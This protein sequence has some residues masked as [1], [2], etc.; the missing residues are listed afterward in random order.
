MKEE[1]KGSITREKKEINKDRRD[2][3][4]KSSLFA[5]AA[6]LT[7]ATSS[8]GEPVYEQQKRQNKMQTSFSGKRPEYEVYALKYGERIEQSYGTY[9]MSWPPFTESKP[10]L[11]GYYY[12][13][14]KGPDAN[15]LFDTGV[16]PDHAEYYKIQKY[17]DPVKM[18]TRMDLKAEDINAIA[19]SHYHWDHADGLSNFTK[20]GFKGNIFTHKYAFHW[21]TQIAPKYPEYRA[22]DLPNK[23]DFAVVTNALFDNKAA[24]VPGEHASAPVEILPGISVQRMDGHFPGQIILIVNTGNQPVVLAADASYM[25]GN[26]ENGWPVGLLHTTLND[27]L[28]AIH[29]LNNHKQNGAVIVPG[30]DPLVAERYPEVKKGIYQIA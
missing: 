4:K 13:L 7:F 26:L 8:Y 30:H 9:W 12:W 29:I 6:I 23:I 20:N 21:L 28:D 2:F 16:A 24:L 22:S 19:I 18:L 25:Y 3:L 5:G 14:I 27:G 17:E 11:Y 1:K 10:I 15:Y